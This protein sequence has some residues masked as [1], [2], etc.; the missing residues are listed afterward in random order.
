M[1]IHGLC[2][3]MCNTIWVAIK[4]KIKDFP[5]SPVVKTLCFPCRGLGFD[6]WELRS[7]MLNGEAENKKSHLSNAHDNDWYAK[8]QNMRDDR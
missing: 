2:I 1:Y 8:V 3:K 4:K 7:C 6:P 5:G